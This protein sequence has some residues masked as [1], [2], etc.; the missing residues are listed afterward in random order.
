MGVQPFYGKGPHRLLRTG[1]EKITKCYTEPP[2]LLC[3][4]CR[5]SQFTDVA[6]GRIIQVGVRR[7]GNP[8]SKKTQLSNVGIMLHDYTRSSTESRTQTHGKINGLTLPRIIYT[9]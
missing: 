6:S 4:F 9:V 5:H 8:C 3:T 1:R 7:F 2:K